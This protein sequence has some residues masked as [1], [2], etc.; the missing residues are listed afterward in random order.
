[1]VISSIYFD[2]KSKTHFVK[3]FKI[4]TITLNKKFCFI[5]QEKGSKLEYVTYRSGEVITYKYYSDK[6]LKTIDLVIDKFID[7][8]GWKS[9]GNKI[10]T[11]KI[12][13]GTFKFK[14]KVER[15]ISNENKDQKEIKNT[16]DQN[17]DV[18]ESIELDLDS[19][20]L[21]IFN[22]EN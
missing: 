2:G 4:E 7:V 14:D 13:S 20:Q 9:I 11:D 5:T 16:N 18:G 15:T 17:F 19:D 10:L 1:M 8:K 3:R 12:R 6:K 22:E 21:N